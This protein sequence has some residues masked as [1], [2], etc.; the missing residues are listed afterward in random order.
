MALITWTS[1]IS[2]KIEEI[3]LQHKKLIE[4][5]NKLHDSMK[6]GKSDDVMHSTLIELAEYSM[7]HFDTEEMYFAKFNYPDADS[8]IREHKEFIAKVENFLKQYDA[9]KAFITID[10]M[11]FIA[12]WVVNHVK[13]T[14]Q[15]YSEFFKKNGLV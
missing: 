7:H 1:A 10:L 5:L 6:V 12:N 9:Q 4:V 14:D 11:H 15:K 8:H 13:G 3:D 2:V